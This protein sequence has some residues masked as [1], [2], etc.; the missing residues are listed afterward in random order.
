MSDDRTDDRLAGLVSDAVGDVE[1][2]DVLDDLRARTRSSAARSRR[3]WFLAVGGAVVA[4]AA[5]VTAIALASGGPGAPRT[6]PGPAASRTAVDSSPDDSS[7]DPSATPDP[8]TLTVASYYLGETP[9]GTRLFREFD[10]RPGAGQL[11]AALET[12]RADPSDPD[13]RDPWPDDAFSGASY[14]GATGTIRVDLR[15]ASLHDRPAGMST[16]E[17]DLA[18]QQVVY[19]LQAAV[20]ERAPVQFVLDGNPVD[21]VLGVPTSEPLTNAPPLDVLSHVSLT[22][23]AEGQAVSGSLAVEGVASS[24][25]ANVRW[26]LLAGGP[27]AEGSFTADGW[28]GEKL[29][30]FRGSIDL[31]DVPPGRYTLLVETDDPSGGAEGFGPDRDTRTVVVR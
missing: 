28:M 22:T 15:D 11:G 7:D 29:F 25:E 16:E 31:A 5:V 27:V 14:P 2:R 12:F 9:R 18:I 1:P 30:P 6:D 4:T 13:Y 10:Q 21:Q 24:N 23:P 3:P 8:G 17:A 26:Q 19:T 20:Q